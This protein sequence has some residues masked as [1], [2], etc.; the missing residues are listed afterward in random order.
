MHSTQR[1][2]ASVRAH[3][4]MLAWEREPP[5]KSLEEWNCKPLP[6]HIHKNGPQPKLF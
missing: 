4:S 3:A 2:C 6:K 1:V 5:F